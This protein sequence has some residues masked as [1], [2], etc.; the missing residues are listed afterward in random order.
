MT[1]HFEHKKT[2]STPPGVA[3]KDG[4]PAGPHD[5]VHQ[6]RDAGKESTRDGARHWDRIDEAI[7]ESFPASDPPS[8]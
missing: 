3:F 8:Y 4:D 7:D 2:R 1:F 5:S 6:V